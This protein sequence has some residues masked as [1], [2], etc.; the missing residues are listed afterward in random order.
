MPPKSKTTRPQSAG[1]ISLTELET[2]MMQACLPTALPPA[3]EAPPV[4]SAS[5]EKK[6][7]GEALQIASM[8]MFSRLA[9]AENVEMVPFDDASIVDSETLNGATIPHLLAPDSDITDASIF[10][11]YLHALTVIRQARPDVPA[12]WSLLHPKSGDPEA[13]VMAE[14][15]Y[16]HAVVQGTDYTI[17]VAPSTPMIDGQSALVSGVPW[18][19]LLHQAAGRL[20]RGTPLSVLTMS[21]LTGRTVS[22]S[23]SV[24][25]LAQPDCI[26]IGVVKSDAMGLRKGHCHAVLDL[27]PAV[28]T[29]DGPVLRLTAATPSYTGPLSDGDEEWDPEAEDFLGITR[30]ER[31]Q[32]RL[33]HTDLI[34]R[35]PAP[36]D[37]FMPLSTFLELCDVF[38][39]PRHYPDA[40]SVLPMTREATTPD[41]RFICLKSAH[42]RATVVS[43]EFEVPATADIPGIDAGE[44]QVMI[45]DGL[46]DS[47]ARLDPQTT[48][49]VDAAGMAVQ[50][51]TVPLEAG[52]NFFTVTDHTPLGF[53]LSVHGAEATLLSPAEMITAAGLHALDLGIPALFGGKRRPL[54]ALST[55]EDTTV[56]VKVIDNDAIGSA[57]GVAALCEGGRVI[58]LPGD[59]PPGP[60]FLYAISSCDV[61]ATQLTL[62]TSSPVDLSDVIVYGGVFK[63]ALPV[64]RHDPLFDLLVT[65]TSGLIEVTEIAVTET[66]TEPVIIDE[67]VAIM[68]Y[69]EV[70][71]LEAHIRD[72]DAGRT[73]VEPPALG[74]LRHECVAVPGDHPLFP[75]S[76]PVRFRLFAKW[77]STRTGHAVFK[78]TYVDTQ[79]GAL[80]VDSHRHDLAAEIAH[81]RAAA[82]EQGEAV[83]RDMES[84]EFDFIPSSGSL[85]KTT[86]R[87]AKPAAGAAK[88]PKATKIQVASVDFVE[89][90]SVEM[91]QPVLS[92]SVKDSVA[93]Q[94]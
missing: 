43:V 14:S 76:G 63:S 84:D 92:S 56:A 12:P 57:V 36:E 74:T 20:H 40:V 39:L 77:Q 16:V 85:G 24:A 30:Y 25:D 93:S 42:T 75:V 9:H 15:M 79:A 80:K 73:V 28:P 19:T 8:S 35:P 82:Q 33:P 55:P 90:E 88:T 27:C 60:C 17:P 64:Q 51:M 68:V 23:S 44:Y 29:I 6:K 11:S 45:S 50:F 53:K 18:A 72:D 78:F 5:P 10:R 70:E 1:G 4:G 67:P 89:L 71:P 37:T 22:V 66:E 47:K 13:P 32:G 21:M 69:D 38:I 94:L 31:Y 41:R 91:A 86:S 83:K 62:A 48:V 49:A 3:V 34:E 87:N 7:G 54:C 46:V 52:D 26:A 59:I 58:T 2:P 81:T 65:T 61:S